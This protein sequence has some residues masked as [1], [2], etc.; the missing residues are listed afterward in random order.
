MRNRPLKSLG[1]A[2]LAAGLSLPAAAATP[3]EMLR[4]YAAQARPSDA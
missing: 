1:I 3:G 2:M 4:D